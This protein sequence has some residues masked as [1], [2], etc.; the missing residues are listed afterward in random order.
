LNESH[1]DIFGI[2]VSNVGEPDPRKWNWEL[3]EGL[4]DGV[5][6]LR[7]MSDPK[8]FGQP[9][10]MDEFKVLPN[11]Y[12]GD[13]GG[14]HTNS[15]IHNKAAYNMLT[16]EDS[17]HNLILTPTEVAAVFYLSLT[18]QLSR[19]SQFIDSRRGVVTSALTLF[20][21]L[22]D[23]ARKAKIAVIEQSFEKVG[24]R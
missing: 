19:T 3:G 23:K 6:A 12:P 10:H 18:Q 17:A 16:G 1:S 4:I 21:N 15:G 22:T 7:D 5:P 8:R 20:R 11:T 9:A 13:W 24:I 14:V 2:I